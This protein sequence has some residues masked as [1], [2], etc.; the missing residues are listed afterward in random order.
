MRFLCFL[1]FEEPDLSTTLVFVFLFC[2][3]MFVGGLSYKIVGG[4]LVTVIPLGALVLWYVT[5][6]FQILL[7]EYQQTRIMTF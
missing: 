3:L 1:I 7:D 2:V 5:Q 4:I 6:P